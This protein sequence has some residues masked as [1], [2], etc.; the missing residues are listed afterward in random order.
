M[1][2]DLAI[3]LDDR[4][5]SL[6]RMGAV[7]GRAG[8]SIEGGGVWGFDGRAIAH[9]LV[10]DGVAA[11]S[12]LEE[13]GIPVL[14]VREVLMQRLRQDV[15][16]QLGELTG[17]MGAAGINIEVQYSNH[18]GHLVLVVDDAENGRAVAEAWALESS[19]SPDRGTA[20]CQPG[21]PSSP[22]GEPRPDLAPP[23]IARLP[24]GRR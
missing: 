17:R 1:M 19:V 7:L 20:N 10:A 24:G 11:R 5:G 16:G 3:E 4:P 23:S 22:P 21:R 2:V 9:F 14:G 13:A 12:A 8:I 15:P 6:A 18:D